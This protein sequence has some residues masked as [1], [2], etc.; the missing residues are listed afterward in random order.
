MFQCKSIVNTYLKPYTLRTHVPVGESQRPG[1]LLEF[2]L[3]LMFKLLETLHIYY[4]DS[5][6]ELSARSAMQGLRSVTVQECGS[7]KM[8]LSLSACS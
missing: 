4:C 2:L 6:K 3:R 7:I 5:L 1:S 8:C